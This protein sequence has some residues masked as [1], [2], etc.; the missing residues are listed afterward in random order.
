METLVE[1]LEQM[2]YYWPEVPVWKRLD[3]GEV[4][5]LHGIAGH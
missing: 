1:A 5:D 4:V 3:S 2:D